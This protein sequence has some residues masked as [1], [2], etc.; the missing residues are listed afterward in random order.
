[1][2]ELALN[3]YAKINLTLDVLGTRPDGFHE[4][5][6]VMQSVALADKLYFQLAPELSLTC[7]DPELP[8]DA[9]NL[10]IK[11][12]RVLQ[13]LYQ[14]K[15][16]ATIH[17]EKHIPMAAGLAGGSS[18]AAATL[19]GLNILW[20]LRLAPGELLRIGAQLGSD[21]PFCLIG[22]TALAQGRGERLTLLP[23]LPKQWL[24]LV[25]PDFGVA[26]CE[27][28]QKW[29]GAKRLAQPTSPQ[30]IAALEQGAQDKLWDSLD[31]H[32]EDVTCQLYPEVRVI[33]EKLLQAG[34]KKAVMSGSGPTVY[35]IME[36]QEA[37]EQA[38]RLL[39]KQYSQV[40]VTYT[41]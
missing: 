3:A 40:F 33:K 9:T 11:S 10:V 39:R 30:F 29:D 32:L 23:Q 17:L 36:G 12:A 25:K 22:G 1:M 14:V 19:W 2:E 15:R 8:V 38:A 34:A 27:I 20:D 4:V 16:G 35:G 7:T 13:E 31:N 5:Q 28:Y 6:M 37:A 18:D 26:T 41:L 24:V 21:I